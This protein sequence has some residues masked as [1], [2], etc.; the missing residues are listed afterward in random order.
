M[1][2]KGKRGKKTLLIDGDIAL[3]QVTSNNEFPMPIGGG[4]FCLYSDMGSCLKA[5]HEYI[6]SLVART[7]V[8]DLILCFSSSY[9]FRKDLNPD[10]KANRKHVRKP[11]AYLETRTEL[12]KHYD[13]LMLPRLEGDD[14]IGIYA[15]NGLVQNPVIVSRD[16]DLKT[17][18]GT[19]FSEVEDKF[20]DVSSEEALF[21]HFYQT[22]VGDT[23]D[24]YPGCPGIGPV[25]AQKILTDK[26]CSWEVVSETFK[27]QGQAEAD[28]LLNARMAFILTSDYYDNGQI[29]LWEPKL[30]QSQT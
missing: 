22:L 12:A 24:N 16:K 9:N 15:T 5:F 7:K 29:K 2:K 30:Q 26:G 19:H 1:S 25:K 21:N 27:L 18:P 6:D 3:F 11:L 4:G 14:V 17:I 8:E 28:A 20:F 13:V 10:Y 23:T